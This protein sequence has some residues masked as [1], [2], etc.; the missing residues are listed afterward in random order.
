MKGCQKEVTSNKHI[1]FK[2]KSHN[3]NKS[4]GIRKG[5]VEGEHTFVLAGHI[6][7]KE[8]VIYGPI[9]FKLQFVD[10]DVMHFLYQA[11]LAA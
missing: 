7:T 3:R 4:F 6:A 1:S 8:S 5:D 10:V 2:A 11:K 9:E